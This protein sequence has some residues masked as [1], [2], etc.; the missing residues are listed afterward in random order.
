MITEHTI[1]MLGWMIIVIDLWLGAILI[2]FL[3]M[4]SRRKRKEKKDE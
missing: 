2:F 4:A 3:V 1:T